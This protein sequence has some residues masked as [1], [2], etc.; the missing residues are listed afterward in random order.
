[1]SHGPQIVAIPGPSIM[2]PR[3]LAAFSRPIPDIYEG[4]LIDISDEILHLLPQVVRTTSAQQFTAISNG[5]GAW[6]MALANTLAPGD[7]VL[8]A[9]SGV[10]A[11][12]WGA[13]ARQMGIEVD[14][15]DAEWG[16]AVDPAAVQ[17]HL[18]AD[19]GHAIKA[20]L[21]THV[22]TASSVRHDLP[23]FRAALDAVDHPALSAATSCAWT[24]GGSTWWCPV[25]RRAS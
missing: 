23:A 22:D 16:S 11:A 15:I 6:E 12:G 8:V 21:T 14:Q 4:E 1:V 3:V 9:N 25:R 18:A 19:T 10:F 7:R 24:S 5:H 13:M 20:V 2:P 17:K